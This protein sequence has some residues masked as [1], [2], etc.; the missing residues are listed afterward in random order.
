[1]FLP[2][3]R[4][5][6][7]SHVSWC[8][9]TECGSASTLGTRRAGR[10]LR[11][12]TPTVCVCVC[13]AVNTACTM[14]ECI[15]NHRNLWNPLKSYNPKIRSKLDWNSKRPR[16]SKRMFHHHPS[17]T[18]SHLAWSPPTKSWNNGNGN[19][20]RSQGLAQPIEPG[21]LQNGQQT[22]VRVL[23]D[24]NLLLEILRQKFQN[25]SKITHHKQPEC[26][27][28]SD[29]LCLLGQCCVVF[30]FSVVFWNWDCETWRL[31]FEICQIWM[32]RPIVWN[33][34]MVFRNCSAQHPSH[35]QAE[36][37]VIAPPGHT[38]QLF[39]FLTLIGCSIFFGLFVDTSLDW[40]VMK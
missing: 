22:V 1:M 12:K 26:I 19:G 21:L 11:R 16:K 38:P 20:R 2:D 7:V 23:S 24:T 14:C 28:V 13:E 27:W 34:K 31:C 17:H 40:P 36:L 39:T 4:L 8:F 33:C 25:L 3:S 15:R 29:S 5:F 18:P 6:H 30:F 10:A 35:A 32:V 37:N 9:T